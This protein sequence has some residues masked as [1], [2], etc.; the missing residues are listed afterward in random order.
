MMMLPTVSQ[1]G[2]HNLTIIMD[3]SKILYVLRAIGIMGI[4]RTLLNSL[5]RDY[6]E[7]YY[8]A[9]SSIT[10]TVTP[11]DIRLVTP[12]ISGVRIEFAQANVEIIFL[13][14]NMLKISWE[15]GKA[16]IPYTIDKIQWDDQQPI[17]EADE[18]GCSLKCGKL[19]VT[20]GKR[21]EII[22]QD[23]DQHTLRKDNS[24]MRVGD[25]WILTT[26]LNTEEHIFGLGERAV[27]FNLR[28]GN[29]C[30]WNRD[31]EGSY[32]TGTDPLYIGTPIYLSL[33]NSGSHLVYFENTFK[34]S[35]SISD[36]LVASFEGGMLRYYLIFGSLDTIFQQ[37]S[38]LLG[39]PTLPPFWA[40]GYHHSRWGY[41]SESD[42]R[43][44]VKAFQNHDLP[45][46]VIHLDIDYMD[47]FRVF[48]VNSKQFPDMKKFT[49]DLSEK[50]ITVVASINPAVKNDRNY[51]VFTDG[52]SKDLFCKLPNG[53]LSGGV[54]WS[55][56]S[57]YPDF[58]MERARQ[59][60]SE[61]YQT[62][63][64]AGISGFW[65][66]MNEPSS[67]S[68][69]G[70]MTL[71][72][73]VK[74]N[75]E[76]HG[77]NHQEVHNLYGLLMNR[78]SYEGLRKYAPD[79]RPW[80]FS[81]A[82]WAGFQKYAWNWTGD[83]DSTWKSLKQTIPTILG[84]GLSGH[85]FS[86]VDI[87]G[88]SGSPGA[89]LYLRWF[90]MATFLPLF[91]THSAIGTKPRE[92]WLFGEPTTGIIRS[93]LK[94]RYK[95]LPYFYTLAWDTSQTG[96]PP[97]RPL[98]WV[99]P[100]NQKLWDVDDEFLLGDGL[101]IAPV[102]TEGAQSRR[103]TLPPG[104]WYSYWDDCQYIGPTEVELALSL[105]TIP[106]F[107]KG[108]TILPLVED[109]GISLHVY[110]NGNHLSS[111][112]IYSDEGDGYGDWRVDYFHIHNLPNSLSITW[113]TEGSYT[114]PYPRVRVV[115]HSK[116]LIGAKA[117]NLDI[118]TQANT[119]VT[120]IFKNL[121]LYFS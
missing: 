17:I 9:K 58:S 106:F 22:Y 108:G 93:F 27:P 120:P 78:A 26:M 51:K 109:D 46:S 99:D 90:Q 53:K 31:V 94:L 117:D 89:E 23:V 18:N 107:I 111:S 87:G 1:I 5:Y 38:E 64:N 36:N 16:P 35:Y 71:P 13:S 121:T 50:G 61:Q 95:L 19:H 113:E 47:G 21:G 29:Y 7:K 62:L 104:I 28:P 39:R 12:I 98:F 75:L 102:L 56:W 55:G 68:A 54:S 80:I 42:I 44:V 3:I 20:V 48:T 69:W 8:S 110:P 81:R 101:L 33:S 66:D 83:I 45:L 6:V 37:L 103:I 72:V 60:W 30:S 11:G 52:V 63:L 105:E 67:F 4:V 73:P 92:P 86:G 91:R 116:Q 76:G 88:F 77:G 74:H 65:H 34:S 100:E 2:V 59:W 32:S 43:E 10:K 49:N 112:H 119:I 79:K 82:G 96:L 115:L 114:F 24:P 14:Q 41:R 25:S 84:L 15:P 40:L 85:A 97:L 70:D 118:P 57:V